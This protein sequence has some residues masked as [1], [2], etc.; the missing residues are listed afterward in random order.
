MQRSHAQSRSPLAYIA[1]WVFASALLVGVALPVR[2]ASVMVDD[3]SGN[4][5]G[6]RTVNLLPAPGTSTTAQGTFAESGGYATM[7]FGGD[8]NGQGGVQLTYNFSATDLTSGN[9]NEQFF[10]AFASIERSNAQ[11]WETAMNAAITVTDSHGTSGTYSTG[12]ASASP[13]NMV[14]NFNCSGGG[15]CFSPNPD[16]TSITRI[17]VLLQFPGN[18]IS[19]STTTA[20]LNEIR[21][22]PLGGTPPAPPVPGITADASP[23][24]SAP[25]GFTVTFTSAGTAVDV[26][27][28]SA[29]GVNISGSAPGTMSAAVSGSGSTYTVNVSGMTGPGTVGIQIPV[30]AAVDNWG[31]GNI[32]SGTVTTT[33]GST[34]TITSS[35]S[36]N[37][38][39]GVAG[40]FTVT[41]SGFP[42]PAITRSS[43][44]LPTGLTWSS[45]T[46]SGTPAVGTGGSYSLVFRASNGCGAV[47]QNYTLQV[48]SLPTITSAAS[49]T[50]AV[51]SAGS[52]T[53][54]ATGSP[55][56]ALSATGSRPTGVTFTDNGDGTAALAG[57]PAAGTG[58]SYPLTITAANG[59]LPNATQSF[60]LTVQ[61]PPAVTS[62]AST[63]FTVGSAGSFTVTTS[64]YPAPALSATGSL[65]SGVTFTDNGNGTGTLA[66]TAAAGTSG[67]YPLTITASNGVL[68]SATQSFTLAVHQLPAITSAASATF[69]AGS[70]G[71]FTV[72]ATGSPTPALTASGSR[73]TGVTFTDNGDGTATLAGTPGAG[74]GASY[75]LTITAANGVLPNATQ[76][77]TLAVQ[78]V[79][80]ITSAASVT[81]T[82]GSAGT[83]TVTTSGYPAPTLTASG[84]RPTGV[85]FTDNGNGTATLAGTPGAGTGGSYSLGI[86]AANGVLPNATQSFTLTVHQLPAI[87]SA[88]ATTFT[89][90]SAGS[91]SVIA[92][93]FPTAALTATGSLPSNVTF[94][95]NGDGTATLAGTP[96]AGTGGSYPLTITAA[97]G[98]VPDA[99]Q[100]FTLTVG[101]VTTFSGPTATGTGTATATFTGGGPACTFSSAAFVAAP[102]GTGLHFPHG[103]FQFTLEGCSDAVDM[104]IT[105]PT[106]LR[107]GT[108]YWKFGPE[109][110]NTPAHWY[111]FQDPITTPTSVFDLTLNDG[112]RGDDDLAVNGT[113]VDQGGPGQPIGDI[114]TLGGWP[115]ALFAALL[116]ASG[117]IVLRRLRA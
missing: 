13:F 35:A 103:L 8:G 61:Q 111:R 7:T 25:V 60:T 101:N 107:A 63:T 45:P 39:E 38:T 51:G 34:P 69:T 47:T 48:D 12:I 72:S 112:D 29:A 91:F 1:I 57:T 80:A 87:T 90:N 78:Q 31:Q 108:A 81:F 114:P 100:S 19:G 67:S 5:L 71:S 17:V 50:F 18:Y 2:A 105:Y 73:P 115:L 11:A 94:T 99:T 66:G 74:T 37:F 33:F 20:I 88:A 117:A 64:G 36:S 95:D 9:T 102:P 84:S 83:F 110:A 46:I 28:F 113:I 106:E 89:V 109:P 43:G 97:N 15:V 32:A 14:F 59:V 55:T 16:W 3:F 56:P 79:P 26:T 52:F 41:A 10:L 76:S 96:A 24:C 22:T 93:G 98:I 23:D 116:A 75:P 70:A 86:T 54:T 82:A 27:G 77:F 30:S 92:S 6:T 62:A 68:P 42:A 21:A 104:S 53:V 58:G 4:R 40:S 65:P 44:T 85:T 49:T